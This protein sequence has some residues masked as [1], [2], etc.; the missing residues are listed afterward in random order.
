MASSCTRGGSR[1]LLGNISSPKEQS[2]TAQGSDGVTVPAGWR[3][4]TWGHGQWAQ[5]GWVGIELGGPRG[6]FQRQW[7]YDCK[8]RHLPDMWSTS[9]LL[10]QSNYHKAMT[11][12][13][14]MGTFLQIPPSQRRACSKGSVPPASPKRRTDPLHLHPLRTALLHVA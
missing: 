3:C 9:T 12:H 4:S 14:V 7:F 13:T 8:R 2:R 11:S 1:W 5:W 10:K 6:L